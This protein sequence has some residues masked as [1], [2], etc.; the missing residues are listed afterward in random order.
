MYTYAHLNPNNFHSKK[1]SIIN[2]LW[3][4]ATIKT[5]NL[6]LEP[7]SRNVVPGDDLSS[8][9]QCLK[10]T[11]SQNLTLTRK[12]DQKNQNPSSVTWIFTLLGLVR[13]REWVRIVWFM[14]CSNLVLTSEGEVGNGRVTDWC[15][16]GQSDKFWTT[17][18]QHETG[19]T[20]GG[21]TVIIP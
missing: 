21:F 8:N 12:H 17:G 3:I 10:T 16:G 2:F 11:Q 1:T 20:S 13:N 4:K 14:L 5:W 18:R 9:I 19:Q 15:T 7:Q 6:S